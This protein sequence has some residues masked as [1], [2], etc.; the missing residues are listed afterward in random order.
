L[1]LARRGESDSDNLTP[2]SSDRTPATNYLRLISVGIFQYAQT[3]ILVFGLES[4]SDIY[5]KHC[6]WNVGRSANAIRFSLA[7]GRLWRANIPL[8]SSRARAQHLGGS[9]PIRTYQTQNTRDGA[10][11][12]SLRSIR[13]TSYS[14]VKT[15]SHSVTVLQSTTTY[16]S[17]TLCV[18]DLEVCSCSL[19]RQEATVGHMQL[20]DRPPVFF[21]QPTLCSHPAFR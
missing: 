12:Y 11:T 13:R 1:V 10:G 14:A 8:P 21:P 18:K 9:S 4:S 3:G 5:E 2:A 16:K 19:Y 20:T 7:Y 6:G 17:L 15:V